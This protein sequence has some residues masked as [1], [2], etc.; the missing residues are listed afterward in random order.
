MSSTRFFLTK[1]IYFESFSH[2]RSVFFKSLEQVI[3]A[4]L[5]KSCLF[6]DADASIEA[7]FCLW[8]TSATSMRPR[9]FWILQ[10]KERNTNP[11]QLLHSN[12]Y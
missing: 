5:N 9:C 11:H 7:L 6:S 3:D 2:D 1:M 8:D 10:K 12:S 4:L